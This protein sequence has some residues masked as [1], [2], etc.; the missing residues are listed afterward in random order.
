LCPLRSGE[1]GNHGAAA[2]LFPQRSNA[3]VGPIR[4]TAILIAASS[5]TA[6]SIMA[7]VHPPERGNHLLAT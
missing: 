2:D 3:S 5:A 7:F 4:R 1:I 6:L